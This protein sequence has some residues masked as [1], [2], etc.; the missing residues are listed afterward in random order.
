M[1][2]VDFVRVLEIY[3]P[4]PTASWRVRLYLTGP[5]GRE[6]YGG[7]GGNEVDY[8][9]LI[10]SAATGRWPLAVRVRASLFAT[11]PR[12]STHFRFGRWRS[13]VAGVPSG[14]VCLPPRG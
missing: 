4:S 14:L 12:P 7:S 5:R 6:K 8:K 1:T 13:R 11:A 2:Y 9:S 3:H 10:G